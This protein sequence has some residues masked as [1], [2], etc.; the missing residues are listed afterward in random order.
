MDASSG[1]FFGIRAILPH[2]GPP[3]PMTGVKAPILVR[4]NIN[5]MISEGVTA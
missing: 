4:D 3:S 1:A 2:L 5:R